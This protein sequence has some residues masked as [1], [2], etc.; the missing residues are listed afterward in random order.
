MISSQGVLLM[1]GGV[2]HDGYISSQL[3]S[4]DLA[5]KEWVLLTPNRNK[6]CHHRLCGP[7]A[8][9][10]HSTVLVKDKMY[11]IFGYNAIYGYL[12]IIQ[13]YSLGMVF[14]PHFV[15]AIC[16]SDVCGPAV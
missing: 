2:T 9:V 13:E 5:T 15:L 3:W 14:F 6:E 16:K 4:L 7:V 8:A 11:V 1:Y 10:G 12:N